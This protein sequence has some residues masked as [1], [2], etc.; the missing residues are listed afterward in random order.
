MKESMR[1]LGLSMKELLRS[2][3]TVWE[4]QAAGAVWGGALALAGGVLFTINNFIIKIYTLNATKMLLVRCTLQTLIFGLIVTTSNFRAFLPPSTKDRL[5]VILQGLATGAMLFL[6]FTCLHY[7]DVGD[8]LTLI[9]T[10]P[11]WS[12]ILSRLLLGSRIGAWKIGFGVLLL[13]G[14]VLT[15]KPPFIFGGDGDSSSNT[16]SEPSVT[17]TL[18][19]LLPG[20]GYYLG[21]TLALG[22]AISGSASNVLIAK[23]QEVSSSVLVF[24]SGLGG[25]IL[26]V[27]FTATDPSIR[28]MEAADYFN[29]DEMLVLSLVTAL[30][31][32]G[33]FLHTRALLLLHPTIV[34]AL[35]TLEIVFAYLAQAL[36]MGSIPDLLTLAGSSMVLISVLALALET[37]VFPT[38]QQGYQE[39]AGNLEVPEYQETPG[40]QEEPGYQV[41]PEYQASSQPSSQEI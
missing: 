40:N 36:L 7:L 28:D 6:Q 16:T 3:R 24:Y 32:L 34:S 5:L 22:C 27:V 13:A 25:V 23:C 39:L 8:A 37:T 35:R 30:G 1:Q 11:L 33:Y 29:P 9:F 19:P 12:I 21:A 26:A 38:R 15:V 31:I 20:L 10:A 14:M 18:P 41:F 4:D 2:L 17:E